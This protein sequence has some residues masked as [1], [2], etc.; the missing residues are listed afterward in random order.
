M[1]EVGPWHAKLDAI[2]LAAVRPDPFSTMDFLAHYHEYDEEYPGGEGCTLWLLV[3]FRGNEPI[4]Y[5][6][7]KR[8]EDSLFGVKIPRITFLVLHDTD[9]P[10]LVAGPEDESAVAAACLRWLHGKV[11][12]WD[13]LEFHQQ[14]E[15][16]PLARLPAALPAERYRVAFWECHENATVRVRWS[17]L[18]DY[19][20]E[21]SPNL[22]S[23]LARQ[24]RRLSESGLA[25][26]VSSRDPAC[27]PLLFDLYLDVESRSWKALA[28][29]GV[30]RSP[31]REDYM[32]ALLANRR[33]LSV[34]IKLLLLD[35]YPV[36]GIMTGSFAGRR[37]LLQLAYDASL[38]RLGP[39]SPMLALCMRDAIRDGEREFN[40][41]SGFAVYKSRWLAEVT[42]TRVVQVYR[43]GTLPDWKRR[44]GDL[45]RRWRRRRE[46][47]I[48]V[49]ANPSRWQVEQE[50]A[51]GAACTR[52][53]APDAADRRRV[54]EMLRAAA[55][56]GRLER[57]GPDEWLRLMPGKQFRPA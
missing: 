28:G 43:R 18:A 12:E 23:T 3:V 34:E 4:G 7:L 55:A 37:Y 13:L 52:L 24:S 47:M 50:V 22:R 27:L 51:D 45:Q 49:R 14:E 21:L 15:H 1:A 46:S 44:F 53:P 30:T 16:S 9:R 32:R 11:D 8:V 25:E 57:L 26:V 48:P 33:L 40:L 38:A 54:K 42:P 5:L 29:T 2:N 19:Y 6:P 31:L 20:A 41:L 17:K 35:G 10:H 36:S 39:G 56:V